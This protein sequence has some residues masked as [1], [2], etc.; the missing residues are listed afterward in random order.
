LKSVLQ[1][2]HGVDQKF[3]EHLDKSVALVLQRCSDTVDKTRAVSN[4]TLTCLKLLFQTAIQTMIGLLDSNFDIKELN[5]LREIFT[6][7]DANVLK[8]VDFLPLEHLLDLMPY[9]RYLLCGLLPSMGKFV[10]SK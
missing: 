3:E 4:S 1:A 6:S 8:G 5:R 7:V 2:T 10:N 9:R